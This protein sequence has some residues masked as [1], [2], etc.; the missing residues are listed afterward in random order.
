MQ[1]TKG[2]IRCSWITFMILVPALLYML[3]SSPAAIAG[4]A[5]GGND[6]NDNDNDDDGD[7]VGGDG[8][9]DA[10]DTDDGAPRAN[11]VGAGGSSRNHAKSQIDA[12]KH[13]QQIHPPPPHPTPARPHLLDDS[14]HDIVDNLRLNTQGLFW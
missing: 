7:T 2:N 12:V 9:D 1:T 11:D 14:D 10:D 6:G 4:Y 8:A 3:S 5:D 13:R